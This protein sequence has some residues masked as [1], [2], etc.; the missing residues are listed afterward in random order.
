MIVMKKARSFLS[1]LFIL[2]S[3]GLP[4]NNRKKSL[5]LDDELKSLIALQT[6]IIS[7]LACLQATDYQGL[8]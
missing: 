8:K 1:R 2:I 6:E 3:N 7:V 5:P 4:G